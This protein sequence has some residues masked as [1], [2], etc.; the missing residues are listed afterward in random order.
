MTGDGPHFGT[1]NSSLAVVTF[2]EA[3]L[4][5]VGAK[6]GWNTAVWGETIQ[7]T[8][9][10]TQLLV[11]ADTDTLLGGG[12]NTQGS[13]TLDIVGKLSLSVRIVGLAN[14]DNGDNDD[15]VANPTGDRNGNAGR[16]GSVV[17]CSA[18]EKANVT[19]AAMN[20]CDLSPYL[21]Q[22][23]TVQITLDGAAMLYMLG[24][25]NSSSG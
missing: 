19:N 17:V 4:A 2:R 24:F 11:T 21:G 3:G 14:D 10:G 8:I 23:A 1:R 9:T 7:L 15:T 5:G 12:E 16:G 25:G 22:N 13:S 6:A 20:G 18:L